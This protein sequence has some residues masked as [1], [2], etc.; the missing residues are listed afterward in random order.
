MSRKDSAVERPTKRV[1][2]AIF[3]ATREAGKGWTDLLRSRGMRL[4]MR[5]MR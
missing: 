4:L 5:G 2:W 1:E 3:F